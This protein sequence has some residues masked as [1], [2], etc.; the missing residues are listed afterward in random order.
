MI[1]LFG[2]EDQVSVIMHEIFLTEEQR[3]NATLVVESLPQLN[4][5]DGHYEVLFIDPTTKEL[6]YVYKQKTEDMTRYDRL[7]QMVLDGK[8]T[9]EEM[10]ELL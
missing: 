1:Y 9:Q 3:A 7:Q 6:K 10:N 8:I 5:P 2:T 4:T